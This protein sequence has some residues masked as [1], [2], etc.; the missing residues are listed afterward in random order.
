[1]SIR[2]LTVTLGVAVAFTG[3]SWMAGAAIGAWAQGG[4]SMQPEGVV[5]QVLEY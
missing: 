4:G 1:M 5:G 3:L 2:K